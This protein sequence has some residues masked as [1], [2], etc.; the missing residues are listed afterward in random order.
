MQNTNIDKYLSDDTVF[1]IITKKFIS[2]PSEK[3]ERNNVY[4]TEVITT[5][6]NKM[7]LTDPLFAK[8]FKKII[9]CGSFYKGT[10]VG[11]PNEFDL[12]IV[13]ELPVPPSAITLSTTQPAFT[14]IQINM[15][16]FNNTS[17][18]Y[19]LSD[20][21]KRLLHSLLINNYL[22]P[23]KFRSWIEGILSKIM[24]E[25]PKNGNW[26]VLISKNEFGTS[27][28]CR[29]KKSGPA[30]T[31]MLNIPNE[32]EICIDLAPALAFRQFNIIGSTAKINTIDKYRNKEWFAIPL[33][34]FKSNFGKDD[35]YWRLSFYLQ[36]NEILA[37]NGRVKTVIRL[38]KKMRD[39]QDWKSIASYFIETLF[40]NKLSDLRENLNKISMTL[41]FYRMLKELQ[42]ACIQGKIEYFWDPGYNLLRKIST[43][44]LD[45]IANRLKNIIQ[46]IEKNIMLDKFI[47]ARYILTEEELELLKEEYNK[48]QNPQQIENN[49][50]DDTSVKSTRWCILQ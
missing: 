36:E 2:L 11:R 5:L 34:S 24:S 17:S 4:L 18:K 38:I 28:I 49:V 6:I 9:F 44:E 13:L 32:E 1:N 41:F 37:E 23:D 45:N 15:Q 33:P 43:R 35:C 39:V 50:P 25:L 8:A 12:N 22:N 21:E 42:H 26:H 7:K 48:R 20:K 47:L 29:I 30:F 27:R 31:V 3:V 19:I 10:K 46:T 14:K 16:A 40:L